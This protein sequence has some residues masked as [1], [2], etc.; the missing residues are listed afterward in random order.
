MPKILVSNQNSF[1]H[2]IESY[3]VLIVL[4]D[5]CLCCWCHPTHLDKSF[6]VG[7]WKKNFDHLTLQKRLK[8]WL[9][10]SHQ[11]LVDFRKSRNLNTSEKYQCT[12]MYS[13]VPLCTLVYFYVPSC[14][15]MYSRVLSCTLLYFQVL[16]CT[17]MYS[18]IFMNS[19]ILSLTLVYFHVL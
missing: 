15:L 13:R 3:N 7:K 14:T 5:F 19:P 16:S 11:T 4:R 2:S 6:L 12:F 1:S 9:I 8:I 18:C 10:N 17:S